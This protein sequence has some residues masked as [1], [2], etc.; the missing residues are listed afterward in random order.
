MGVG[1]LLRKVRKRFGVVFAVSGLACPLIAAG[2][3]VHTSLFVKNALRAPGTV[4]ELTPVESD[5]NGIEYKPVFSFQAIDK[6]T[7][8][9][10][11]NTSTNPP[12][13]SVGDTI[14]V[15]YE[16]EDPAKATPDAFWQ[17]WLVPVV[18]VIIGVCHGVFGL[19]CLY[20]DRRYRKRL[21][22]SNASL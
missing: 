21:A 12:E 4:V 11:S 2:F 15:L 19:A 8:T 17:L 5:E 1:D 9:I 20:F 10:T 7:Y 14:T 6:Q 3:F 13:F 18:L 16:K 22:T